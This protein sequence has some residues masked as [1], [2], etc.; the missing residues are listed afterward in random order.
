MHAFGKLEVPRI[1]LKWFLQALSREDVMYLGRT[2]LCYPCVDYD[3][4]IDFDLARN[5]AR[6]S[7][8]DFLKMQGRKTNC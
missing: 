4:C 8:K 3:H 1:H 6:Q 7:M 2:N 5:K